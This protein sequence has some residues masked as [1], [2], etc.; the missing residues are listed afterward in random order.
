VIVTGATGLIGRPL[1]RRLV[2]TAY[3]VVAFSR[4]PARAILYN[5]RMLPQRMLDSGYTFAYSRLEDAVRDIIAH[6]PK[7]PSAHSK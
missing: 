6:V 4:D 1:T 2:E 3:A 5:H 7:A